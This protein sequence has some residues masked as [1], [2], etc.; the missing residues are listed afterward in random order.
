MYARL[1]LCPRISPAGLALMSWDKLP[2]L[3]RLPLG[4]LPGEIHIEREG[5]RFSFP[6][7][8]CIVVSVLFSLLL[9]MFRK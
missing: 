2:G 6:R 9:W 7:V 4:R 8:T 5:F 3:S 1:I